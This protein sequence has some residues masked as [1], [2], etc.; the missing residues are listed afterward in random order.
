MK[1]IRKL[2]MYF[3]LLIMFSIQT[4]RVSGQSDFRPGYIITNSFDTVHGIIDFR[5]EIKNSQICVFKSISKA[6]KEDYKPEDLYGYRFADGKFYISKTVK[7]EDGEKKIF[8]EYLI[9]GIASMYYYRD[10]TKDH[11]LFQKADGNIEELTNDPVIKKINGKDYALNSN[12][13]I[14]TLAVAFSDCM[15]IQPQVNS[16]SLNHAS[17][18]KL[19]KDYHNMVCKDGACI[20]YEKQLP[21]IRLRFAPVVGVKISSIKFQTKPLFSAMNFDKAIYPTYG[22][23]LN[24]SLPRLNEKLFLQVDINYGKRHFYSYYENVTSP[25]IL[26]ISKT[27]INSSFIEILPQFKYSFPKGSLRPVFS[28]GPDFQKA[29]TYTTKR[30][31]YHLYGINESTEDIFNEHL[32]TIN[33][34]IGA[35]AS[36]GVD[37]HF[38]GSMIGFMNLSYEYL[39][40]KGG[41]S[42]GNLKSFCLNLGIFL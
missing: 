14:A 9:K 11:Y 3:T 36:A 16:A 18:I 23:A 5:G 1:V 37:Y 10:E 29:L 30:N 32:A 34:Y 13:Y 12:K 31:A 4:V 27:D 28:L 7:T 41:Q 24:L 26:E 38:K 42:E 2:F 40:N 39:V 22:A 21:L 25:T 19:L 35:H 33:L 15:A 6:P 17:M 20:I 8:L